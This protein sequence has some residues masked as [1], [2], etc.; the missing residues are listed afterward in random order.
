MRHTITALVASLGL[1]LLAGC[2]AGPGYTR[3]AGALGGT[4]AG[5]L[6]GAAI[7][8]NSGR[9]GEGA[10]LGGLLGY[11]A[12]T[13]AAEGVAQE[14]EYRRARCNPPAQGECAPAPRYVRHPRQV[15]VYEEV[16]EPYCGPRYYAP[17]PGPVV[18]GY[19]GG[20]RYCR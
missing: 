8:E 16:Y 10:V 2:T 3:A 5:A 11:V 13:T 12:G 6:I 15:V 1:V 4:G 18:H 7:G 17:Y 20:P 19:Y 14:Q 9:A